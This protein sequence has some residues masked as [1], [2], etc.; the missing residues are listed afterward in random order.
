MENSELVPQDETLLEWAM[1]HMDVPADQ[2]AILNAGMARYRSFH[3]DVEQ[4][5]G[6]ALKLT[7]LLRSACDIA[8]AT[9]GPALKR[10]LTGYYGKIAEL[11]SAMRATADRIRANVGPV[12]GQP[13][14][15]SLAELN[16]LVDRI[17]DGLEAVNRGDDGELLVS[18]AATLSDRL[19][20]LAEV[21]PSKPGRA[22]ESELSKFMVAEARKLR[23]KGKNWPEVASLLCKQ[24]AGQ[25][26]IA[27]SALERLQY[28]R[29][30]K[31]R[32]VSEMA[33]V[34]MRTVSY[35]SKVSDK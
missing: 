21:R 31:K 13:Y 20:K 18:I 28:N 10:S 3:A 1:K 19:E 9:R 15:Q 14:E 6:L 30:G 11:R 32:R 17:L 25:K 35:S 2:A 26:G 12:P 4:W 5:T 33:Q 23:K 16:V 27:E 24:W 8:V 29:A 22:N 34:L 7:P